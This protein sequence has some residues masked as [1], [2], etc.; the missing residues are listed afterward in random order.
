MAA[1]PLLRADSGGHKDIGGKE[2]G[3]LLDIECRIIAWKRAVGEVITGMSRQ[4]YLGSVAQRSFISNR[5]LIY[6]RA[7]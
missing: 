2:W 3:G 7:W 5:A 1:L 6:N 4:S